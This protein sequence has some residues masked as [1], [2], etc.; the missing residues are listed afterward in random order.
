V[1]ASEVKIVWTRRAKR[2]LRAAYDY[3]ERE[4][5]PF[6]ADTM[7]ERIFSAVELLERHS[8]AG[9]RGRVSGTRELVIPATPFLIAYCVRRNRIEVLALL[10]G[11]RK[12]PDSF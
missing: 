9:R 3:W 4:S 6:A 11:A 1:A 7:L 5:S 2:H 12:W 8:E 10:L